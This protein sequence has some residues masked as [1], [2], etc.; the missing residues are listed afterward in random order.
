MNGDLSQEF[1]QTF[2]MEICGIERRNRACGTLTI[3]LGN[4]IFFNATHRKSESRRFKKIYF[5]GSGEDL[6]R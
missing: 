2:I 5:I 4:F 1:T 6:N 3:K